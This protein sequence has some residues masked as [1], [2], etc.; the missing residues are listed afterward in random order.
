MLKENMYIGMKVAR[1]NCGYRY[2]DEEYNKSDLKAKFRKTPYYIV[3]FLERE[4]DELNAV[5]DVKNY[6]VLNSEDISKDKRREGH[7]AIAQIIEPY[8][9]A[10][11]KQ[12]KEMKGGN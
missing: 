3:R 7:Y 5:E 6:C 10:I 8:D 1:R 2:L 9:L 12:N 4:D 11:E